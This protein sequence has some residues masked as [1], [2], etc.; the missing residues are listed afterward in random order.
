MAEA[1]DVLV[2]SWKQNPDAHATIALC[3]ALSTSAHSAGA[4]S[5]T[6][7]PIA[8]VQEV[9]DDA[10][11]R[12]AGNVDVLVAVGRMLIAAERLAE[13]QT[14]L[15]SA[16]KV[17]PREPLVYR[18]L[19]EALMRRGDAEKAERVLERA[20]QLGG[21]SEA[22]MWLERA[23]VFK[24]MQA[25]SGA[26]AVAAEVART[27]RP[28]VAPRLR[29]PLDSISDVETEIRNVPAEVLD[30]RRD[31][32]SSGGAGGASSPRP[33]AGAPKSPLPPP[34]SPPPPRLPSPPR[35][36]AALPH[37]LAPDDGSDPSSRPPSS[38]KPERP[39]LP[40][41]RAEAA[42]PHRPAPRMAPKEPGDR[43]TGAEP[44]VIIDI[45]GG[46]GPSPSDPS[47]P[48]LF[49][50]VE[51]AA[52][53]EASSS[54][55][56]LTQVR[57]E[58]PAAFAARVPFDARALRPIG[59][60][61][62]DARPSLDPD[63]PTSQ[64]FAPAGIEAGRGAS[65]VGNGVRAAR[66]EARADAGTFDARSPDAG[67]SEA[68]WS[69]ARTSADAP[70]HT[71][72]ARGRVQAR[73]PDGPVMPDHRDVLDALALAGVFE[74]K[75]G[76]LLP[77]AAWDRPSDKPQRKGVFP[78]VA[79][80]LATLASAFGGFAYVKH[81]REQKRA[82]AAELLRGVETTLAA[83]TPT[84]IA[85]VEQTMGRVFELDSRSPRAAL[86]WLR[87]RV[88]VGLVQGGD[89]I[90]FE[91]AMSRAREVGL[92][93]DQTAFAR[94]ASFL[95]QGD[96]AGAAALLSKWDAI[97]ENDAYYQLLA[98]ATLER[99]GDPRAI[100]R[101]VASVKLDPELVLAEVA[102]VRATALLGDTARAVELA[103]DF[104][105]R[106]PTRAEA[107]VLTAL[108]WA[109]AGARDEKP[110]GIDALPGADALPLPLRAVPPTV[111]AILALRERAFDRVK[112]P[113]ERAL[114]VA[115][116]PST[117]A[118]VGEIALARGDEA[119]ARRAALLALQYSAAHGGARMLAAR[120]AL[121]GERLDEAIKATEDMDPRTPDVAVIR[122]AAA[123]EAGDLDGLTRA[124]DPL[125][126]SEKTASQFA[127]LGIADAALLGRASFPSQKLQD[128]ANADV[129]WG[130]IIAMDIALDSG[131]L[132]AATAI[133]QSWPGDDV[134]ASRL[135]RRARLAR[136]LGQLEE[137]DRLSERV[138][139]A[140]ATMRAVTERVYLLVAR[141]RANDVAPLLA[142][143]PVVLGASSTWLSA[144][145]LASSDPSGGKR[146]DA[147]AKTAALDVPPATS[148]WPF[149]TVVA[150]SLGAM[151]DRRRGVDLLKA[152]LATGTQNHDVVAAALDL[153][154]RKNEHRGRKPTYSAP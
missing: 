38:R 43:A 1:I 97:G 94:V 18:W 125:P 37:A 12:H 88:V 87:E 34:K 122:A 121:Q 53:D 111:E 30:L 80:V 92:T 14:L 71:H 5:S 66:S 57:A 47:M 102:L 39:L 104:K 29:P 146:E 138:L 23:R 32:P 83:A 85:P 33:A 135:L 142:R 46:A 130:D 152:M 42:P 19:G 73:G 120:V 154:F 103:N 100:E 81:T 63:L 41:A 27:S 96:T 114:A 36:Q 151:R 129:P 50:A 128:L 31:P 22:S 3:E 16:G 93:E 113:L 62:D 148:S 8:Q 149:R 86:V 69:E 144:F 117:A 118:W 72:D 133:A 124:L 40:T 123:Y 67:W 105:A 141:E 20:V 54:E 116:S 68:G 112:P 107:P 75:A 45:P 78:L 9:S 137:A 15:V 136:Y 35:M 11:R 2:Q 119:L 134:R 131:D 147:K 98:G 48:S 52:S 64:A 139:A 77:N 17:A 44:R 13:A 143:Y 110:E 65:D 145:A 7:P 24:P 132:E 153:G 84:D 74:R 4:G 89:A 115:D 59:D 79:I 95:F 90:A 150:S 49:G 55:P 106:R 10:T 126:E 82:E 51:R 127:A 70:A 140:G 28:D 25:R 26:K 76:T 101:Y 60:A 61:D 6:K 109:R 58:R 108:A 99:A 21:G 56:S 91:D